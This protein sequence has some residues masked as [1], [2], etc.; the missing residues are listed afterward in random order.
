MAGATIASILATAALGLVGFVPFF[1]FAVV[2]LQVAAWVLRGLVF[3]Y[4]TLGAVAAYASMYRSVQLEPCQPA[5]V[6]GQRPSRKR[7][8]GAVPAAPGTPGRWTADR[9]GGRLEAGATRDTLPGRRLRCTSGGPST[10][11]GAS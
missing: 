3:Q 1:W 5:G 2:P 10:L 4:I 9:A 6:P 8:S 7:R 11:P